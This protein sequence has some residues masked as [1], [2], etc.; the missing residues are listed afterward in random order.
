M[1]GSDK[2][3]IE[4]IRNGLITSLDQRNAAFFKP[5]VIVLPMQIASKSEAALIKGA[6]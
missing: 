4:L 1:Y 5:Q 2:I 3:L 6:V